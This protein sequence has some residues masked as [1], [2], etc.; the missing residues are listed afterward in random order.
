MLE[1]I[2]KMSSETK[3]GIFYGVVK[4]GKLHLDSSGV[5]NTWIKNFEG[6]RV[7]ITFEKE[8]E[9]YSQ[10]QFAYLYACIYTPLAAETGFTVE[11]VDGVL[12]KMHLTRNKNTKRE[13]VKDKSKLTKAEL[14]KYIDDCIQTC[15]KAG[16]VVLPPNEGKK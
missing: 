13:Y 16:V 7:Q 6:H 4:D 8:S 11:E 12:K 1:D 14:A 3:K 15:A 10:Q 5:Y 9:K 2:T